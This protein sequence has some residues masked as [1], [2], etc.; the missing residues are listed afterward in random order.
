MESIHTQWF[1]YYFTL[2][3][4]NYSFVS[5]EVHPNHTWL[6]P[7][8]DLG[9]NKDF[10]LDHFLELRDGLIV[11]L[12]LIH[13]NIGSTPSE[14]P[15]GGFELRLTNSESRVITVFNNQTISSRSA[16]YHIQRRKHISFFGAPFI[17]RSEVESTIYFGIREAPSPP[18]FDTPTIVAL[19]S[20]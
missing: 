15:W 14:F 19:L 20:S 12:F 8:K 4:H 5:T 18:S 1:I 3:S 2:I 6:T 10:Y 7:S 17:M 16:T 9:P 13:S 11:P